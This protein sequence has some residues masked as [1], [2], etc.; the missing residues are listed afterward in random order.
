MPFNKLILLVAAS[1]FMSAAF[2]QQD[3]H[4]DAAARELQIEKTVQE[5]IKTFNSKPAHDTTLEI[6]AA[7]SKYDTV[8]KSALNDYYL[9]GMMHRKKVF[10]W[11]LQSSRIAFWVVVF[12]VMMGILFAGIQFYIALKE[13]AYAKRG[14]PSSETG[15][16]PSKAQDATTPTAAFESLKTQL[17]AGKDGIKLSSPVLGVIILVISLLFFY[18]YLAYVY[19]IQE[20]F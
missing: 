7:V 3:K 9:F 11:N 5:T 16:A 2:P 6:I 13:M 1:F 8:L 18:L 19:P 17:E 20:I 10:E 4:R 12:L 15:E 14:V